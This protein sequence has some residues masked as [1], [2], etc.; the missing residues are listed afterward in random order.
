VRPGDLAGY[1]KCGN[2]AACLYRSA[3]FSKL[4]FFIYLTIKITFVTICL[5]WSVIVEKVNNQLVWLK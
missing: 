4:I 5:Q 2:I 1:I 3:I